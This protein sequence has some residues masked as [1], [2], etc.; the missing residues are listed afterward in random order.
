VG[1]GYTG[2]SAWY[3]KR[4]RVPLVWHVSHDTDVTPETLDTGRNLLRRRL[5]KFSI[6][7]GIRWAD[8]IV[9]QTQHQADL[10]MRHYGRAADMLIPNFHPEAQEP[11]DKSGHPTVVWIANLKRW[12]RPEIFVRLAS[13]LRDLEGV[14]F[15]MVGEEPSGRKDERWRGELLQAIAATPNLTYVGKRS[16]GEV[17][18][19][20]ARASIFVNTSA[21]EGFPNTFIQAW[22]REAAI[23]SLDVNPDRVLDVEEVGIHAGSE[24]ELERAVRRLLTQSDLRSRYVARA[25]AYVKAHHSLQNAARLAQLIQASAARSIP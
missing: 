22:M 8:R 3:A 24:E 10:L 20:L 25:R 11:I 23:V 17:N 1:G 14:Q 2:I 5:E 18:Q 9:V 21:H 16:Q 4:R 12:K 7:L 6:R 19:L 13:K 15:L